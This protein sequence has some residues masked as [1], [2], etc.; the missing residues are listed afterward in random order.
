MPE[1]PADVPDSKKWTPEIEAKQ[2]TDWQPVNVA[3][4]DQFK[5][6]AITPKGWKTPIANFVLPE[7][8]KEKVMQT[9]LDYIISNQMEVNQVNVKSVAQAMYDQIRLEHQEEIYQIIADRARSMSEEEFLKA[10]NNSAAKNTDTP[11]PSGVPSTE[12]EQRKKAY[13]METKR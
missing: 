13:E 5:N 2:K 7:E 11:P 6:L 10:Y 9:A 4:L 8:D 3:M 12:E 1:I